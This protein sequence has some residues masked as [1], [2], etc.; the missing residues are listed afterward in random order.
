VKKNVVQEKSFCFALRIVKLY[1][2]LKENKKEYILSKQLLRS[3]TSIGANIEEAIGGQSKNDFI[4]K[5]SVAYKE[6]RETLYWI[7]LLRESNYLNQ[8]QSESLIDDCEEI[9]KII[10]KIQKTMKF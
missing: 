6:S 3:G 2:Y 10:T 7:K 5:I 4:S 1:K 9:I 8:K